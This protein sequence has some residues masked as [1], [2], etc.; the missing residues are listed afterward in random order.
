VCQRWSVFSAGFDAAADP[1]YVTQ[2]QRTGR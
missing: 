1:R 2:S